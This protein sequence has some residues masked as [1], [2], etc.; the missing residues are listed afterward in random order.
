MNANL[1]HIVLHFMHFEQAELP[2]SHF[3]CWASVH[4][5]E[6]R[7][8]NHKSS[9]LQ[10]MILMLSQSFD[11][12]LFSICGTSRLLSPLQHKHVCTHTHTHM[13]N[14]A[15]YNYSCPS[16]QTLMTT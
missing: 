9:V 4:P 2:L 12:G 15:A 11:C 16:W 14:I 8:T 5:R 7:S 10:F 13:F 1:E 3:S 6:K